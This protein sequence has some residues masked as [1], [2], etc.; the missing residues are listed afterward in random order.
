M[1]KRQLKLLVPLVLFCIASVTTMKAQ[2]YGNIQIQEP[3]DQNSE[4]RTN[5]WSVYV[6]SGLSWA[7]DVWYQN[8]NATR[9]YSQ[10]PALGGGFDYTIQPWVRVGAEYLWS[11]YRREQNYS[12]I[13]AS[14]VP[15][16]TYGK[17]AMNYHNA[18]VGAQFNVME[19]WPEREQQWLNIWAG[20]GFGYSFGKGNEY[21]IFFS[22]TQTQN[23]VT[24]PLVDGSVINNGSEITITGNVR[25]SNRHEEFKSPY[26]PL[27]L[28]VEADLNRQLTVGLKGEMDWLF[29]RED[30]APKNIILGMVTVRYNFVPSRAKVQK[31]YYHGVI[32]DMVSREEQLQKDLDAAKKNAESEAARRKQAEELNE[33]LQQQLTE[34]EECKAKYMEAEEEI[35][36]FV[37]FA[38]NSSY[39]NLAEE[40]RLKIF[41][42]SVKGK[43]L[44]L[45]A[46]ASTPG[47]VEY[48][49][50]LSEKRLQRVIDAL[51]EE[52]FSIEDLD[53][54]IA[55]GEQN[56][57]PDARGRRVTITVEP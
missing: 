37:Q 24:S 35:S 20:T 49:Q 29:H 41:A 47:E 22:N 34:C 54:R 56:G 44:S 2:T 21:G 9:S 18:K 50:I 31:E 16:K 51:L 57:K 5:K 43:R 3:R 36:H 27:S 11:S 25:T 48:N 10:S 12:T 23:G 7:T 33:D 30:I 46:E 32:R 40:D 26:I 17:Y 4:I 13:D 19:F 55:I 14:S 42:Q 28:H 52:G 39:F 15:V 38:H 1:N 8:L 6:Q 45:I 53:P